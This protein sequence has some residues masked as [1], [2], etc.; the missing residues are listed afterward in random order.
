MMKKLFNIFTL[1][2]T[3]F[4]VLAGCDNG[5]AP[6]SSNNLVKVSLTVEG[7]TSE[8]SQKSISITGNDLSNII[9]KYN[10]VPQWSSPNIYGATDWTPINYSGETSLGY[11]SPGKWVFGVQILIGD[12]P[13]YQGFSE[14]NISNSSVRVN[15]PVKLATRV[16]LP[17]ALSQ[18]PQAHRKIMRA[19]PNSNIQFPTCP[20]EVIHLP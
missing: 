15:V 17:V 20:Q 7:D 8:V 12:I 9:Y 14:V 10:A 2:L 13:I 6:D 16:P 4:F 18:L 19:E 11:F 5:S 1:L 3:L